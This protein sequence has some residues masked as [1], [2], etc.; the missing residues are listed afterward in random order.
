MVGTLAAEALDIFG[1][2]EK[3]SRQRSRG[4]ASAL[5]SSTLDD[6]RNFA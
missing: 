1:A 3:Q 6:F 5:R 2:I 4:T